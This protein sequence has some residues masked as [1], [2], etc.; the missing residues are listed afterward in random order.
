MN[1]KVDVYDSA[2]WSDKQNNHL[3][4]WDAVIMGFATVSTP[5]QLLAI[6]PTY[7][8]GVHDPTIRSL[9]EALEFASTDEEA[10][11]IW[12]ELQGYAW[13]KHKYR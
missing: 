10:K 7:A 11:Q 9:S 5:T 12:D 6:S 13:E 8:G 4:D 3:G 1:V 2:T